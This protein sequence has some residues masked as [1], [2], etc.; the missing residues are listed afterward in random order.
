MLAQKGAS[1]YWT[2]CGS[3]DGGKVETVKGNN[4]PYPVPISGGPHSSFCI[5]PSCLCIVIKT[6]HEGDELL[7]DSE[8]FQYLVFSVFHRDIETKSRKRFCMI[9]VP[10]RRRVADKVL[11]RKKYSFAEVV[12]GLGS[13]EGWVGRLVHFLVAA[14]I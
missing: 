10:N 13:Q 6:V 8:A 11:V 5:T 2:A 7:E 12:K 9:D 14:I 1:K 3:G 4:G